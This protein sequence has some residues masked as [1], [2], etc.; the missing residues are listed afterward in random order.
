MLSALVVFAFAAVA[1]ST[2]SAHEWFVNGKA[3]AAAEKV[4]ISGNQLPGEN[5]LEGVILGASVHISCQQVVLPAAS[6]LLEEKGK[7]KTKQEYKACTLSTVNGEGVVENSP[8]CKIANFNAEGAGE[9]SEAGIIKVKGEPFAIIK[10]EEN[11]GACTLKGEYKV[12]TTQECSLPHFAVASLVAVILCNPTGSKLLKLG[13]EP[14]K[15]YADIG[16]A[17]TKGQTL[18][19]N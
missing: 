8:K 13:V 5:Q 7:L 1:S 17:G 12:E 6:N 4:E 18:S 10:I 19:S 3:I 15:L 2:A 16:V 9:L 14:A 11:G